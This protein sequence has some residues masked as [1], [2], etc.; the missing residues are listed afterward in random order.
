MNEYDI[1]RGHFEKI[2]G[3]KL[4]TIM[5]DLFGAVKKDG[6]T[7]ISNFGALEAIT[8]RVD[9]KKSIFVETKMNTNVDDKT[10]SDTIRVY[11]QFLERATGFTSKERRKKAA[12]E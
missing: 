8:V 5:R 3:G 2:E 6:D 7:L 4:E 11:N 12:K 1:K 10:A 9:S